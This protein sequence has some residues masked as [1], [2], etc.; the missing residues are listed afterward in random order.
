[1]EILSIQVDTTILE[2][3]IGSAINNVCTCFSKVMADDDFLLFFS[4][5]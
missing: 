5:S 3:L 2:L 4:S 1:M